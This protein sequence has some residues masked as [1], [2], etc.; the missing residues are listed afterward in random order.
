[1]KS[2][3]FHLVLALTFT[4]CYSTE[5]SGIN[6]ISITGEYSNT[7]KTCELTVTAVTDGGYAATTYPAISIWVIA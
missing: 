5:M 7:S 4:G 1:M 6:T 3:L 2:F